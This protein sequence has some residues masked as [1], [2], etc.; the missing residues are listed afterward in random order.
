VTSTIVAD[1]APPH[2]LGSYMSLYGLSFNAGVAL[3]PRGRRRA[4]RNV[5]TKQSG[6]A[7]ALAVA[8]TGV[9]CC[10]SGRKDNTPLLRRNC[11][12]PQDVQTRPI[13]DEASSGAQPGSSG[14][15]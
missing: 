15:A 6:G 5:T 2:M 12:P 9:A 14:W 4:A 11:P 8:L 10:D 13:R 3:G 7:G 1:L